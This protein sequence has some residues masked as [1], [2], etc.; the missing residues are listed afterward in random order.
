VPGDVCVDIK[1]SGLDLALAVSPL[2]AYSELIGKIPLF[3]PLLS[4]ERPGLSTALFEPKGPLRDPEVS[5][6]PLESFGRGLTWYPSL[7]ID[8]RV[9][10]IKLPETALA[11]A[12]H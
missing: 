3:G 2:A 9:N 11:D 8:L 10:T 12:S 5:Y 1:I 6:L 7:A 4:G